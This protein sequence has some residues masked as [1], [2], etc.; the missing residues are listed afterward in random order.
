[1]LENFSS[2]VVWKKQCCLS[3]NFPSVFFYITPIGAL[4]LNYK[5][6]KERIGILDKN[7]EH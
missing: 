5:T 2:Q 3:H 1:M 4:C 6:R 7:Y